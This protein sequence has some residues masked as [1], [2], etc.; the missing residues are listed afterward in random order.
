MSVPAER[1]DQPSGAKP[2]DLGGDLAV[3]AQ[4][5]PKKRKIDSFS[6]QEQQVAR[7]VL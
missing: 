5:T 6:S 3:A 2:R 1:L 7:L 4:E